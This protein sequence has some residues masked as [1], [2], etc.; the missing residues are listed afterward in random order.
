MFDRWSGILVRRTRAVLAVGVL[1]TILAGVF[2]IGVFDSLG[3]GGFDD[4]SS[5]ASRELAHEQDSFGNKSPDVVAIYRSDRMTVSDPSFRTEVEQTLAGIPKGTTTSVA[6][7]WEH[8]RLLDGEQ[9]RARHH[10]DDLVGGLA[11]SPSSPTTT[12]SSP[13]R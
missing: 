6:T 13:R 11:A 5:E 4:P 3:Q 7:Y 8:P 12:T 9:G 10:R 2:G 1:A